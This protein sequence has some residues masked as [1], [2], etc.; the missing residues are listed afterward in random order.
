MHG[1]RHGVLGHLQ[2]AGNFIQ[3]LLKRAEWAQPATVN[4]PAREEDD[5]GHHGPEDEQHRID[6]ER[7]PA[8]ATDQAVHKREH[9][10]DGQLPHGIPADEEQRVGQEGV[11]DPAHHLRLFHQPVLEKQDEHQHADT[12]TE[13]HNLEFPLVPNL[14]PHGLA[15]QPFFLGNDRLRTGVILLRKLVLQRKHLKLAIQ[16]P[17]LALHSEFECPGCTGIEVVLLANDENRHLGEIRHAFGIDITEPVEVQVTEI[18]GIAELTDLDAIED[19]A[20]NIA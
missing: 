8:E 16:R 18:E 12:D 3:Q 2:L 10:D 7:A 20:A 13:H 14:N 4:R 1:K 11:A 19:T 9:V 15:F 17:S 6:K 5:A